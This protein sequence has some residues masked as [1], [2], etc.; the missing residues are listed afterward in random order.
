MLQRTE[1][2]SVQFPP[3][4]INQLM[5]SN[6]IKSDLVIDHQYKGCSKEASVNGNLNQFH[7]KMFFQDGSS[8]ED[9]GFRF[10]ISRLPKWA[11]YQ[12]TNNSLPVDIDSSSSKV[13]QLNGENVTLQNF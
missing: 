1:E 8:P 2:V 5:T 10:S 7:S 4:S 12:V 6:Q 13:Q 9:A 11:R 3:E